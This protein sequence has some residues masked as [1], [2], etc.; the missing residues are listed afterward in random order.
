MQS[1]VARLVLLCSVLFGVSSAFAQNVERR[2]SFVQSE[3]GIKIFVRATLRS[4]GP[5]ALGPST[6]AFALARD[7]IRRGGNLGQDYIDTAGKVSA[8]EIEFC[9]VPLCLRGG[10]WA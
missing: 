8:G 2:D 9:S 10:F 1:Q 3:P 4:N 5:S 6:R 7:D